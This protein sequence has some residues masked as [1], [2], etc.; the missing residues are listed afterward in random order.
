[1]DLSELNKQKLRKLTDYGWG[2]FPS[3]CKHLDFSDV[4]TREAAADFAM[5]VREVLAIL[6][7]AGAQERVDYDMGRAGKFL[8]NDI[9]R[10][11]I[12]YPIIINEE[13]NQFIGRQLAGKS[14]GFA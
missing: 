7:D 14:R 2:E 13:L 4:N 9:Y 10:L 5:K 6:T 8:P 3:G 1:V 11:D 12:P